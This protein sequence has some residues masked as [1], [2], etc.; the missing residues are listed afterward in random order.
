MQATAF[1]LRNEVLCK[2]KKKSYW[3]QMVLNSVSH[4]VSSFF[5]CLSYFL[6]PILNISDLNVYLKDVHV[7]QWNASYSVSFSIGYLKQHWS[8]CLSQRCP[9]TSMK[10][11]LLC[12]C[13]QSVPVKSTNSSPLLVS[14]K[15]QILKKSHLSLFL[16]ML[17]LY[18]VQMFPGMSYSMSLWNVFYLSTVLLI[19]GANI[20]CF[21]L[22]LIIAMFSISNEVVFM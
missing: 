2:M 15:S 17:Q 7:H 8:E 9:C 13:S 6:L 5:F 20:K 16:F 11:S 21:S 10:C 14:L 12:W 19:R 3:W 1:E 4:K 18:S 22:L